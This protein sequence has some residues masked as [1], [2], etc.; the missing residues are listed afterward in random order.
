MN[1]F[2]GRKTV[3]ASL[4]MIFVYLCAEYN[5]EIG[6]VHWSSK[7]FD[8]VI[9]LRESALQAARRAWADYLF[10]RNTV[11]MYFCNFKSY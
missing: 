1:N 11:L 6:P 5:D 10:V 8:K 4:N 9:A 7:R 2:G 3:A